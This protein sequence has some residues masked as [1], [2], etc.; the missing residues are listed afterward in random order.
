MNSYVELPRKKFYIVTKLNENKFIILKLECL[1]DLN[2]FSLVKIVM[3]NNI[4]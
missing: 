4:T 2:L 3:N 1:N